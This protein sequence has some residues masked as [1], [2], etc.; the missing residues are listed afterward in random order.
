[1]LRVDSEGD[2]SSCGQQAGRSERGAEESM[3]GRA[4]LHVQGHG[5]TGTCM[6]HDFE[7][8]QVFLHLRIPALKSCGGRTVGQAGDRP[9]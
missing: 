3:W 7:Q 5:D 8:L 9:P 2:K 4:E 1:M 6:F